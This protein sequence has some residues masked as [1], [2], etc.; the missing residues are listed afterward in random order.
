MP[1][2]INR[3]DARRWDSSKLQKLNVFETPRFFFDVYCLLPGQS[4]KPHRHDGA[5]KVYAV[6]EGE[7]VVQVGAETT[8]VGP[9]QAVLA[10]AG[11]EHGLENRGSLQAAVLVFMAPRPA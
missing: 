10:P 5:D 2:Q 7:V 3:F 9:G 8:L 1:I 11:E 4:Q 6:A